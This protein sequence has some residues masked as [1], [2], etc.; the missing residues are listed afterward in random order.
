[1]QAASHSRIQQNICRSLLSLLV[2]KDDGGCSSICRSDTCDAS[3]C[4]ELK[5]RATV[6][7]INA[8]HQPVCKLLASAPNGTSRPITIGVT[9]ACG[10]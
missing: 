6:D 9:Q 1:M 5:N 3:A 2:R 7:Q 4:A 8:L 10:Y